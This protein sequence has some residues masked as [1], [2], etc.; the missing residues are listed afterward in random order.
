MLASNCTEAMPKREA[1]E[2]FSLLPYSLECRDDTKLEHLKILDSSPVP[3]V[4]PFC[5]FPVL[6]SAF[7]G[8]IMVI[9]V[10]QLKSYLISPKNSLVTVMQFVEMGQL[11]CGVGRTVT[12]IENKTNQ[13]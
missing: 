11:W 12:E 1:A 4:L 13:N 7:E 10:L 9:L 5:F 8:S 2:L 6:G 3:A